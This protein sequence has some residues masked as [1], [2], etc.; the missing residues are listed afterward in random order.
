MFPG[1]ANVP[2]NGGWDGRCEACGFSYAFEVPGWGSHAQGQPANE[3]S[4]GPS[5]ES[6]VRE[7]EPWSNRAEARLT[8]VHHGRCER[9]TRRVLVQPTNKA[10]RTFIDEAMVITGI[11]IRVEN[12]DYGEESQ[13]SEIELTMDELRSIAEALNRDHRVVLEQW[14]WSVDNT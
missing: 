2:W 10:I 13:V 4:G 14:G 12:R 5:R 1:V 3:S 8:Q 6:L 9:P 11:R 7:I